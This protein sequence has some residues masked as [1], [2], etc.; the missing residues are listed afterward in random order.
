MT[1]A[2]EHP[3]IDAV[4]SAAAT[5]TG[6][7]VVF[8]AGIDETEFRFE[9]V[10]GTMPGLTE[11][12]AGDRRDSFCARMLGGAPPTTSDAATDPNYQDA[13][14]R[15]QLGIVSY[16]GVPIRGA[17]GVVVGTLCGIDRGH[18]ESGERVVKVLRDLARILGNHLHALPEGGPV[19][20][21]R[22]ASGW[23]V[24]DDEEPE[25]TSAMVL[26]DLLGEELPPGSRPQRPVS[27]LD[28]MDRLRLAVTQLEH[29]LHARVTVEQA[30]GVL[31]ERH[32]SSPRD[33]FEA[34]RKVARRSGIRVYD[35]SR[36][37]VASTTGP[38]ALPPELARP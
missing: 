23:Q 26:A 21:R 28:E 20:I 30:I 31:A 16:V 19:V 13:K 35:L 32:S 27:E 7:E 9:R 2:L 24:G 18:V 10:V 8:I 38:V 1:L 22:T 36:D 5:L 15:T 12:M 14:I 29:A 25:L 17:D 33:A 6:M 4:L 37:V 34:L 11:G 3:A